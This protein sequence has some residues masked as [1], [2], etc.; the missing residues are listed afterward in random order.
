MTHHPMLKLAPLLLVLSMAWACSAEEDP[1]QAP[2][3]LAQDMA[4]SQDMRA[5]ELD[6]RPVADLGARD[7]SSSPDMALANQDMAPGLDMRADMSADMSDAGAA[8]LPF[9]EPEPLPLTYATPEFLT[10]NTPTKFATDISC[11]PH[12]RNA[13]DILLPADTSPRGLVVYIHGGGFRDGDKSKYWPEP[14]K[15]SAALTAMLKGGLAVASIN[16]RLLEEPDAQGVIKPLMDAARCIQ[17]IRYHAPVSFGVARERIVLT[18]GSAGAGTALWLGFH[19]DLADPSS[20][21][22]SERMST[23]PL[24]MAVTRTQATYDLARWESD[25]FAEFGLTLEDML[26]NNSLAERLLSFYG[27]QSQDDFERPDI[28]AY[29]ANVDMLGLMDASDPTFWVDNPNDAPGAPQDLGAL[30]HHAYHARALS[31]QAQ[32]VQLEATVSWGEQQSG[33]K[34]VDFILEQ[35]K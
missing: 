23:K 29:R 35:L 26:S 7:M 15:K 8:V 10:G 28:V 25:V 14:Q 17:F 4:T 11:G 24:A 34:L 32:R 13:F 16:Y 5:A 1:T 20:D 33:V 3:P 27:I 21:V 18:G 22:M 30:L 31:E 12:Q 6:M 9:V 2:E 19:D